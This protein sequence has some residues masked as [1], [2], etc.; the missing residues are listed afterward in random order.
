MSRP[1]TRRTRSLNDIPEARPS[2]TVVLAR[3]AGAAPELLLVRRHERSSFGGAFAFPGGVLEPADYAV[4]DH[5][6]GILGRDAN[7]CLGDGDALAYFSAAIRELFE[8]SGVL[9]ATAGRTGTDLELARDK[10]NRGQLDWAEFLEIN[11]VS[12]RCG[13]LCY[14]SF[15][16]NAGST[17][18]AL[19]DAVLPCTDAREPGS[20]ALWR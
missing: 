19:F 3:D 6:D 15:W 5:C 18:E 7:E 16:I 4:N 9:L 10:L 2:S 1:A 11:D 14:F 20:H 12:L 13:E 8:E 17:A